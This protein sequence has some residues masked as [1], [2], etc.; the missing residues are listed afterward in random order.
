MLLSPGAVRPPEAPLSSP[1]EVQ[2]TE[3]CGVASGERFCELEHKQRFV[4]K[5]R[6]HLMLLLM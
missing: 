5:K 6:G 1:F 4:A 3:L 2:A